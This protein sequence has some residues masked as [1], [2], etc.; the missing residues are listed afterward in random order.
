M[1]MCVNMESVNSTLDNE[2]VILHIENMWDTIFL[3][4]RCLLNEYCITASIFGQTEI[5]IN[6][7]KSIHIKARTREITT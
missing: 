2:I 5:F 6:F 4:N 1:E 3:Q 7:L